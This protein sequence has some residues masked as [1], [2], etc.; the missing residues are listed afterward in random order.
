VFGVVRF[1]S[2]LDR[3]LAGGLIE[4]L[5]GLPELSFKVQAD[6]EGCTRKV[7]APRG[8]AILNM[9]SRHFDLDPKPQGFAHSPECLSDQP[10]RILYQRTAGFFKFD[11]A[12]PQFNSFRRLA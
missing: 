5:K 6:V 2:R 9:V 4:S 3:W 8:R 7:E 12:H 11:D 1:F 10:S